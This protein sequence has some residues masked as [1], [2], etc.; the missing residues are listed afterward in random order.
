MNER[1]RNRERMVS[2]RRE[3]SATSIGSIA[4]LVASTLLLATGCRNEPS[5]DPMARIEASLA[6]RDYRTA[7]IEAKSLLSSKPND[8][9][10]R[11]LLALALIEQGQFAPALTELDKVVGL[12]VGEDRVHGKRAIALLA[13]GRYQELLKDYPKPDYQDPE[14]QAEVLTALA[15][16]HLRF[17]RVSAAEESL[18]AAL[19][20]DPKAGWALVTQ[21]R[22]VAGRGD[23]DGALRLLQQA[24]DTGRVQGEAWHV[25]GVVLERMRDDPAGAEA[26][27]K[28]AIKDPRFAAVA[29]AAL[30]NLYVA[31]QRI[32]ELRE[33]QAG[34]AKTAPEAPATQL[35][36]A[37]LAYLESRFDAAREVLDKLLRLAPDN[38]ELLVLSGAVD[39]RRGAL[40]HAESQL[41]R[42]AQMS[43]DGGAARFLLA[44]TYL[45][46]G[47]VEKTLATLRPLVERP[48]AQ[49]AALGMAGDAYLQLGQHRQAAAM[50][51]AALAR[52][53]DDPAMQTAV[54]LARLLRGETAQAFAALER[55]AADDSGDVADKALIS[56]YMSRGEFDSALAAADRLE[57]KK[58]DRVDV[59]LHRGL[60]LQAKGDGA[61]AREAFTRVLRGQPQHYLA[62]ASLARLDA[63]EGRIADA[64]QRL[65]KLVAEHPGNAA[66]W[67]TLAEFMALH[68]TSPDEAKQVLTRAVTALPNEPRI[69]IALVT[70]LLRRG[71]AKEALAVAQQADAA[72]PD[73]PDVLDALGRA[74]ADAGDTQQAQSV[75]GR[76]ANLRP[77]SPLPH[78]RLA[79][80]RARRGD[81]VGAAR[82]L[83]QVATLAPEL[84]DL[85]QRLIAL[86]RRTRNPAPAL[87]IARDIQRAR[88]DLAHGFIVEGD[89]HAE[90]RNWSAAIAAFRAG[91]GKTDASSQAA[92]RLYEA[93]RASRQEPAAQAFAAERVRS[94]AGDGRFLEHVGLDA[95]RRRS[96]PEAERLFKLAIA[97]N[98]SSAVAWNN[99]AWVQAERGSADAV[100]S[101]ERAMALAP[102]SA[103]VLDTAGKV[104]AANDRLP[105]ALEL[106]RRAVAISRQAPPY[107]LN[108][109]RLL[110]QSGDKAAARAELESLSALGAAFAGQDA[111]SELRASLD[112]K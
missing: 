86:V 76:I 45:Q 30:V 66:P 57:K 104:Y 98:G 28:E 16:A 60:I 34:M 47:Q 84:P 44:Q 20:A 68:G 111:V 53:P 10:A 33:I 54:S 70:H 14:A 35:V 52:R 85:H 103:A 67:L 110:A 8:S 32:P 97:A 102:A 83:R 49:A 108:L 87:D 99:L 39:L 18:A 1:G 63:E 4:V 5:G 56:A 109:A 43:E 96:L 55:I 42:A 50:F 71:D 31:Q 19:R 7:T 40:R 107:R 58:P 2:T 77:G 36:T 37:Q 51:E 27:Y 21:A 75:F 92:I 46:M 73:Q 74:L 59:I 112:G 100:A 23:A 78:L 65:E 24:I 95:I 69:R 12:G 88:P 79:D 9:K 105:K 61:G 22:I 82:S 25:K 72:F 62:A 48:D 91:L 94:H 89:I 26:A 90:R 13:N 15:V 80:V 3:R 29:N 41:G 6:K 81:L 64:R 38:Q 17:G 106:Q 11:Y 101:V 93:L